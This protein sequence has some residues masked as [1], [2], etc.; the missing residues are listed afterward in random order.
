MDKQSY[1]LTV[2]VGSVDE[3]TANQAKNFNDT[4]FLVDFNN[5]EDFLNSKL[6]Q[7]TTVYTSLGD[8]PGDL[9]SVWKL[10]TLADSVVYCPT[11]SWNDS[12]KLDVFD[13][14]SSVQGLT[15]HLLMLLHDQS[16]IKNFNRN[17]IVPDP[18]PVV[19]HRCSNDKQVWLVG[20]SITHGIGV[21]SD[22]RYGELVAKELQLP[23]SFLTKPGSSIEWS[24][25]QILRSD[26]RP[27]DMVIWGITSVERITHFHNNT[28]MNITDRSYTV[29]KSIQSIVPMQNLLSQNTFY[30]HIYSIKKVINFCKINNVRL[31]LVGLLTS[32][33]CLRFLT[34]IPNFFQYPYN[35]NF[36]KD[37]ITSSFEDLGSDNRHPG[38]KQHIKYKDFILSS[39]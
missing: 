17:N 4:A 6:E 27:E 15:E 22:Q 28:L 31:I 36:S 8:L 2:F 34:G 35:Y 26:I 18:D 38:P 25:G 30:K 1:Q 5:C 39:L 20:C 11:D 37:S 13:P 7:D 24:A 16:K 29:D 3:A 21:N 23:C 33:T 9:H 10:L 32:P 12:R 19:G 14:T